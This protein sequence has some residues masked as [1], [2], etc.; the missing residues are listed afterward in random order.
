MPGRRHPITNPADRRDVV[1]TSRDATPAEI[2]QAFDA[3]SGA[4]AAWNGLGGAARADCL[5]RTA[6]LL[7]EDPPGFLR[8]AG[9]R[10][11]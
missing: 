8:V 11:G 6:D 1:G 2:V 3:S 9:P 7:G 10:S 5:E 4:Q